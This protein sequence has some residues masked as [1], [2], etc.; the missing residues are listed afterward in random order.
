MGIGDRRETGTWK[1]AEASVSK[2]LHV[3]SAP[4][5]LSFS[6][7]LSLW[8]PPGETYYASVL[9]EM[10]KEGKDFEADSWSMAV[11]S[12]YLQTHRKDVIKRQD[13]I[14]GKS[15]LWHLFH[16]CLCVLIHHLFLM[17]DPGPLEQKGD[18]NVI[19]THVWL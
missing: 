11:E 17:C 16:Q 3:S 6:D 13:V 2:M 8:P 14:Y 5:H 15:Y 9:E 1:E 10:E 18:S 12:S 7:P 19:S 4:L